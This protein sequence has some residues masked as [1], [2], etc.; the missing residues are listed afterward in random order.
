M[1]I[2]LYGSCQ[3]TAISNILNCINYALDLEVIKNWVYIL[4][5]KIL[6]K[7]MFICDVFIYQPYNGSPEHL[8][9]HTDTILKMLDPKIK[10]I[11]VPFMCSYIHWPDYFIDDRNI[12]TELLPFGIFP[13]QSIILSKYITLDQM[14]SD[15]TSD[16]YTD[17]F[18]KL[19]TNKIFDMIAKVE[20]QC[21]IKILDFIKQHLNEEL[22]H[23]AQ[24]PN[25]K[26]LKHVTK[27][28][29]DFLDIKVNL[30]DISKELLKDHTV[31]ILPCVQKYFNLHTKIY[32]LSGYG[33]INEKQYL[34][35]YFENINSKI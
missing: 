4:D 26:L 3:V 1:K 31:F 22:F 11:S 6:P 17:D 30:P 2:V 18:L 12:K 9:Y 28:I 25:N 33:L 13:Q 8:E 35:K 21:D 7:S 15:Y 10:K 29:I 23:S 20:K 5:K 19:N 27:Q 16:H 14:L 34:I 24:H 32:K